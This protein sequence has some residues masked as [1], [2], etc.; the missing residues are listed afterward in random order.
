[1]THYKFGDVVLVGFPFTN[2]Q[3]TKK[4]PAVVLSRESYN[5]QRPDII[6]MAISSRVREPLE[7]G[8]AFVVD[9]QTAGLI[10]PSIFK[11]LIATI[12]QDLVLNKLGVLN[13]IDQEMLQQLLMSILSFKVR[14]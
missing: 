2:L 11:P 9:W 12:E 7:S 8:E 1:M 14:D 10:K 3:T 4:R 6:L 13:R 5:E